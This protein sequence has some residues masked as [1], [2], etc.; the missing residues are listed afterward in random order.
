MTLYLVDTSIWSW[1]DRAPGSQ[2]SRKLAD[3]AERGE[4][5]TCPVVVLE[6]LHRGRN[7]DECSEMLEEY[8]GPLP[9]VPVTSWAGERAIRVQLELAGQG[10]GNHRRPAADFLLA[11]AAEEAGPDLTLWFFDKDLRVICEH[12]GQPHEAETRA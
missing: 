1:A 7:H 5:A 11:A 9:S 8:F 3:R 10:H 2:L 12:T 4:L 6:T